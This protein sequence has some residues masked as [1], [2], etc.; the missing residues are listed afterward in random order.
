[1]TLPASH[2]EYPLRKHGMDHDRYEWSNLFDR[3]PVKWPNGA[4]VALMVSPALEWFPFDMGLEP[5]PPP[6]GLM[7]PYPDYWN[8]TYRDYGN[9]VGIYRIAKI[10]DDL[11][12]KASVTMNSALAERHPSLVQ[13]VVGR[14]WE[15]VASGV[16]MGHLHHGD[17][18]EDDERKLVQQ[19]LKTLREA[20]GQPVT[21]WWSPANSASHNTLDLL[22]AEGV[23]YVCDW[24]NDDLPYELRTSNGAIHSMPHS[25]ELSDRQILLAY[26]HSSE[27]FAEQIVAQFRVLHSEAGESGGRV[28]SITLHP[29]L[30]GQPH[31]VQALRSALSEIMDHDGVWAATGSE[32]LAAFKDQS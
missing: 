22:A 16:D 25:S 30:S 7:R 32:I 2:L 5:F 6:G 9:R 23:E 26:H 3:P 8:Y 31:R 29:W 24:N 17:L 13:D 14:G 4:R 12:I 27:E 11:G 18:S 1:M 21:G 28:M 10:L 19:S 20:S 15:I